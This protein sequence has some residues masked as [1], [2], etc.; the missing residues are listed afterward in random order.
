VASNREHL[1]NDPPLTLST[2]PY[3]LHPTP[4]RL[5]PNPSTGRGWRPRASSH[6]ATL[7]STTTTSTCRFPRRSTSS[8]KRPRAKR[9]LLFDVA[10]DF[11]KLAAGA[12]A[13]LRLDSPRL[14]VSLSLAQEKILKELERTKEELKRST[15]TAADAIESRCP[16]S[17]AQPSRPGRRRA[18]PRWD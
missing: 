8:S 4:V 14:P 12:K 9:S 2:R 7:P 15:R 17:S 10:S 5:N 16:P 11:L 18:S 3:T 1:P 6:A 13:L